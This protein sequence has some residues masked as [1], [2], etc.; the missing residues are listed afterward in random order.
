MMEGERNKTE[1]EK[2][3]DEEEIS[4]LKEK[5]RKL[6]QAISSHYPVFI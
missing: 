5:P 4:L 2:G 3:R 6:L 1:E